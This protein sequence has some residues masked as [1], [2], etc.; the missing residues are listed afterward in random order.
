M[1]NAYANLAT[2]FERR[3]AKELLHRFSKMSR[4]VT[5]WLIFHN[6]CTSSL[7]RRAVAGEKVKHEMMMELA[8]QS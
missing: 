6:W 4:E 3:M 5:F 7:Y 8:Q 2:I 1:S